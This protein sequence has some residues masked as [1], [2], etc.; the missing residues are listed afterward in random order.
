MK[1]G[2]KPLVTT[3]V[4][5]AMVLSGVCLAYAQ[6]SAVLQGTS[7]TSGTRGESENSIFGNVEEFNGSEIAQV[8]SERDHSDDGCPIE[9]GVL[10]NALGLADNTGNEGEAGLPVDT[11]T[12]LEQLGC[13]PS[14]PADNRT[15]ASDHEPGQE[16]SGFS[17]PTEGEGPSEGDPPIVE[18]PGN[19]ELPQ[20]PPSVEEPVPEDVTA[21]GD[22]PTPSEPVQPDIIEPPTEPPVEPV[23]VSS[24]T[25]EHILEWE[26]GQEA[27]NTQVFE[28]ISVGTQVYGQDYAISDET[29]AFL[30]SEPETLILVEQEDQNVLMLYYSIV[31]IN[32]YIPEAP[33][34][35]PGEEI[36]IESP[37]VQVFE[38]GSLG[39]FASEGF[40]VLR[41]SMGMRSLM[42]YGL[43]L[44]H[45]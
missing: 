38:P 24:L 18:E 19:E 28:D 44:I 1:N 32:P 21:P 7:G 29:V 22:D 9:M 17:S 37:P 12:D 4:I 42:V 30:R 40:G 13:Q 3:A 27:L 31:D 41:K 6:S 36:E 43:S 26:G 10:Q 20:D 11:G 8:E 34:F 25:V 45:I 2:R 39:P 14:G 16:D 35:A 5:V 33:D 23:K 15:S